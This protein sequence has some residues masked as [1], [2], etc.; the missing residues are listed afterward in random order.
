MWDIRSHDAFRPIVRKQ[1]YL[2]DN[3]LKILRDRDR[4]IITLLVLVRTARRQK[5]TSNKAA[6]ERIF[7]IS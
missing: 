7:Q 4:T 1:K 2:T 5:K 6:N 3:K